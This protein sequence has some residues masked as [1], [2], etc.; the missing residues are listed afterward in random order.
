MKM[1]DIIKEH[2]NELLGKNTY[3]LYHGTN[4]KFGHFSLRRSTQGIIWF[5]DSIDSIKNGDHGGNGSK[6]IMTRYVTINN[7]A[8]WDEYEKYTL[9]QLES[10]GYDG[11]IL[12]QDDK[13]DYFVFSTKSIRSKP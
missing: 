9:G 4:E 6:Y 13:T 1:L 5:T 10:L 11:V 2:I 8:G 7:P 3:K 12:P